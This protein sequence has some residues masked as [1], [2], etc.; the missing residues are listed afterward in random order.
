MLAR[1]EALGVFQ[2]ESSGMRDLLVRIKPDR[3]ADLSAI[4]ALFR[5]GPLGSGMVDQYVE[6]KHGRQ[7]TAYLHRS[8]EPILKE[9]LGVIV[10]Q[11]QVMRIANV[12]AGFTL[13][14]ADTLRKA[15]GKKQPE[16]MAKYRAKFVAG[17]AR[18][19]IPEATADEIWSQMEFFAGYGFNKSH[20]VAYAVV[21]YQTAWMKCR[22]PHAYMAALLTCECGDR[23]KLA[24][25][26]DECRRMGIRVLPPD[27]SRSE[28]DFTVEGDAIRYGLGA[29]KG[30]GEAAARAIVA[31]RARGGPFGS[32]YDLCERVDAHAV[33]RATLE[34][35]VRGGAF[36]ST[37]ARRTQ[38]MEV[39]DR[40]LKL[41]S[42]AHA[43]RSAGQMGLFGAAAPDSDAVAGYPDVPES[44]MQD[45]LA[46]EK[47]ALAYYVTSHPLAKY[48]GVLRRHASGTSASLADTQEKQKVLLGGLVTGFRTSVIKQGPNEGKKMAFF[49][50]EDFAGN[51]SCV[52]FSKAYAEHAPRLANDRVVLVEG[53]V[54]TSREEPTL[55]V[56]RVIPIEDAVH[57]LARGVLVRLLD[58]S[59]QTLGP[60][61]DVLQAH[62]GPLPVAFEFHP[63]PTS[64]IVL[65]AAPSWSV[66]AT[67]EAVA[68][69]SVLPG[70]RGAEFLSQEP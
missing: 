70:V 11:E 59:P 47:D 65:K 54:D 33:N 4:L 55:R 30:V 31:A 61:R 58:A 6:R 38:V 50:L 14:E 68:R 23:D 3:F 48:E 37:G 29:V 63:D 62:P 57:V 10:Y 9:T 16:K 22:H 24:E 8:L 35:L 25:Y 20:T 41:A 19:G 45:L 1:G 17:A 36:D 60:V 51:A 2:L 67:P 46:A 44:P 7:S 39:L 5:P 69:L 18:N 66:A 49:R 34:A 53:D 13:S 56:N 15:M 27:V 26:I 12:L 43:D 21:A 40:A 28:H 64:R 52:I 42:E 32:V